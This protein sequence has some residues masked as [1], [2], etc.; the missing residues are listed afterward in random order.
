MPNLHPANLLKLHNH[1]QVQLLSM[2]PLFYTNK[3][4]VCV[5]SWVLAIDDSD[6]DVKLGNVGRSH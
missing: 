5:Q 1:K 6:I 3:R 4:K 2:W